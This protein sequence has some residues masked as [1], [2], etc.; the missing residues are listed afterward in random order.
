MNDYSMM[1]AIDTSSADKILKDNPLADLDAKA[2]SNK[3]TAWNNERDASIYDTSEVQDE[4]VK[5][6]IDA[7]RNKIARDDYVKHVGDSARGAFLNGELGK[8]TGYWAD[9]QSMPDIRKEAKEYGEQA[10]DIL[11]NIDVNTLNANDYLKLADV[12]CNANNIAS[13][14]KDKAVKTATLRA[15]I[16]NLAPQ[17][18]ADVMSRLSPKAQDNFLKNASQLY[19]ESI[20]NEAEMQQNADRAIQN[21]V[22][23]RPRPDFTDISNVKGCISQATYEVQRSRMMDVASERNTEISKNAPSKTPSTKRF[24]AMDINALAYGTVNKEGTG[25]DFD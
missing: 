14:L 15:T 17:Q 20:P 4:N 11:K 1:D 18:T 12:Q 13:N 10:K 9:S 8:S 7:M 19:P 24:D 16:D 5:A 6:Y 25:L 22:D 23:S 2:G 21:I 3:F